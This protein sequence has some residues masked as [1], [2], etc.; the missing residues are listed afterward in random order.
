MS[1]SLRVLQ[2]IRELSLIVLAATGFRRSYK[3]H[4]A[5][6]LPATRMLD[7]KESLQTVLDNTIFL[8]L[9]PYRLLLL[10]IPLI[11]SSWAR[12][13]KAAQGVEEHLTQTLGQET[14]AFEEGKSGSGELM[15][16]FAPALRTRTREAEETNDKTS[17]R[18][19][20]KGLSA[21]K[22]FGDIFV[23]NFA[24]HDTTKNTIAFTVLLLAANPVVQEWIAEELRSLPK[25]YAQDWIAE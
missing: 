7:Y 9:V 1:E 13:G 11:P 18:P 21:E 23:I 20:A 2:K 15:T 12:I 14:S 8:M 25:L 22:I 19:Q 6:G 3:F 17:D 4:G 5:A 16:F 24:G 10:P